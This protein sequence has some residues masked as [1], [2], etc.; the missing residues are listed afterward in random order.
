MKG[1][2]ITRLA[3][4]YVLP[5]LPELRL[6]KRLLYLPPIDGL[7]C[8]FYFD[9]SGFDA[10]VFYAEMF[11]QA[12]YMPDRSL[13]LTTGLRVWRPVPG[14]DWRLTSTN[15]SEVMADLV[16]VLRDEVL[17]FL[18]ARRTPEMFADAV[19]TNQSLL[20]GQ[21]ERVGYSLAIYSARRNEAVEHL[22]A[23]IDFDDTREWAIQA[24]SRAARLRD[25][26]LSSP[27]EARTLLEQWR[28]ETLA[29]TKLTHLALPAMSY[30]V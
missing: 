6:E 21:H 15:E 12:L 25:A 5:E 28:L 9:S 1:P 17:P 8:G 18:E 10:S 14:E 22:Q 7:L 20:P 2:Q 13:D 24:R 11:V 23:Y 29:N 3:K 4:K 16:K 19:L 30:P 27:Q 26:V